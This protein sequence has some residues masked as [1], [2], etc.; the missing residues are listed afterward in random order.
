MLRIL[1][2]IVLF[3]TADSNPPLVVTYLESISYPAVARDAQIQGIVDVELTISPEGTVV[4]SIAT[5]GH[6][7]L[8]A[9][10]EENA[11]RWKFAA[12]GE[13]KISIR[14]EFLLEEPKARGRDDTR[15]YYQLPT[16]VRV[17]TSLRAPE[18]D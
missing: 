14:Y 9:A 8:K 15:N 6:P 11:R 13:K 7:A 18:S 10:A 12:S 5:S 17:V 4:S 1:L 2:A 3:L 16:R